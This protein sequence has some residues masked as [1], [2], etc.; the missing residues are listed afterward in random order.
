MSKRH[1][2]LSLRIK[3]ICIA[4][5][6]VWGGGTI[7][8]LYISYRET[9]RSR[10]G[11]SQQAVSIGEYIV[12]SSTPALVFEDRS[13]LTEALSA[14]QK[15]PNL[16]YAMFVDA[17]GN[18]LAKI[19]H[20][21][22]AFPEP[23]KQLQ[24]TTVKFSDQQVH[25]A[26]PIQ[27]H[28]ETLG[29]FYLGLSLQSLNERIKEDGIMAFGLNVLLAFVLTLG[30]MYFLQRV[31]FRPVNYLSESTKFI[32]AGNF[33]IQ[34]LTKKIKS[35]DELGQL[36]G[37]FQE[38]AISLEEKTNEIIEQNQMLKDRERS[39][40][41]INNFLSTYLPRQFVQSVWEH[42]Q[43]EG[44]TAPKRER[45]TVFFSDLQGFTNLTDQL[46]PEALFMMLSE[47]QN[48]MNEIVLKYDGT[49]DKYMGDGLM[50][51]FGAPQS[52][53]PQED[54]LRCCLMAMEMQNA[55]DGLQKSWF[56]QG[57]ESPLDLR[58]GVHTGF[59]TVGSFGTKSRLDYTAIGPVV[60]IASRLENSCPPGQVKVSH[61]SWANIRAFI[62]TKETASITPKGLKRPMKTYVLNGVKSDLLELLKEYELSTV[63]CEVC[64][65]SM[66]EK[67]LHVS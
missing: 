4:V 17:A 55:M 59:S 1:I 60:N 47:Y 38:M 52:R 33:K 57:I 35:G 19:N 28:E 9:I 34:K 64:Q 42:N 14:L 5:L 11:I 23:Q 62:E 58:I 29:T 39:L 45:L 54:A 24:Q 8:S 15:N 44:V 63:L 21:P 3:L 32:S 30:M 49:L 50:V 37:S 2:T 18:I 27:D 22:F 36:A 46:D 48:V 43:E 56:Y 6:A 26:I 41:K 31:I 67:A 53:G 40:Q 16:A 61:Q 10:E 12:F 25:V 51:F 66:E 20:H 65:T 13:A 7:N